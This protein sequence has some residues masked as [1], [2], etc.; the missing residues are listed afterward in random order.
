MKKALKTIANKV[1]AACRDKALLIKGANC[2]FVLLVFGFMLLGFGKAYLRPI[3]VNE[4]ENRTAAKMPLPSLGSFVSGEFQ[5]GVE[6]ALSDQAPVAIPMKK[7]YNN[8]SNKLQ[9]S[10]VELLRNR[11]GEGQFIGFNSLIYHDGYLLEPMVPLS[12]VKEELDISLERI[13]SASEGISVPIYVYYVGRDMDT[14]FALGEVSGVYEYISERL[15]SSGEFA[16]IERFHVKNISEYKE[17][18]YMTDHHY[19]HVGAHRAYTQVLS[20]LLPGEAPLEGDEVALDYDF[21][22]S[23]SRTAGTLGL[24]SERICAYDYPLPKVRVTVNNNDP[25]GQYGNRKRY[26]SGIQAGEKVAYAHCYGYDSGRVLFEN[27]GVENGEH[28]LIL[29]DS[30]D[31]AYLWQLSAHFESVHAIDLRN[32]EDNMGEG[33]RLSDYVEE[34]GITRV[35][36]AGRNQFFYETMQALEG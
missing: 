6:S 32:Y 26:I 16:A 31:N 19:N 5:S 2:A 33:F 11:G 13:L 9:L 21:D 30:Y 34:N 3:E 29:G 10:A 1:S 36:F 35:V 15:G 24:V 27:D 12:E 22:G 4:Y 28:L 20:L 25:I 8:L 17:N 23:R 14:D 18:F 7:L